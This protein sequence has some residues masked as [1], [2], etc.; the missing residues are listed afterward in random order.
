MSAKKSKSPIVIHVNQF[1][2]KRNLSS[3]ARNPPLIVRRKTKSAKP[4]Y[5]HTADLLV[6]NQKIGSLVQQPDDPLDCGARIW[7]ELGPTLVEV[8]QHVW[9]AVESN[10][11]TP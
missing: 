1:T 8:V 9:D 4:T 3:G 5:C 11:P 7:L 6:N 2:I 10:R